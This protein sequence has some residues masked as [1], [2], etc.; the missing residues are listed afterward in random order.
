MKCKRCDGEGV[1][2]DGS[3]GGYRKWKVCPV[4]NG[5]KQAPA[6]AAE[7]KARRNTLEQSPDRVPRERQ[8]DDE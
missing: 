3:A 8:T 7:H 2:P 1:L 5:S 4:C 6:S